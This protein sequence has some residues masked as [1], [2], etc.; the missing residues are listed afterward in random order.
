MKIIT[1]RLF[2]NF[3][4]QLHSESQGWIEGMKTYLVWDRPPLMVQLI[5]RNKQ[6]V[7]A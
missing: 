2:W 5:P 4:M 7:A 3:D 6:R 1:A